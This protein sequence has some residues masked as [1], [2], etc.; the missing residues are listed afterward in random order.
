MGFLL[1]DFP[2]QKTLTFKKDILRHINKN[3]LE[4]SCGIICSNLNKITYHPLENENPN[5][6]NSFSMNKLDF[7]KFNPQDI[8]AIFHSH[9]TGSELASEPDRTQSESLGIPYYIYGLEKKTFTLFYPQSFKPKPLLSRFFFPEFQDCVSLV[10][11]FFDINLK[12][13]LSKHIDNWAR[14]RN[15]ESNADLIRQ[16]DVNFHEVS[17]AELTGD[18]LVFDIEKDRPFHLGV[19]TESKKILHQ[20]NDQFSQEVYLTPELR[21]KVYKI[22]RYKDL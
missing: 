16:L 7:A 2:E 20:P 14:R 22:Y 17:D 9:P 21:K 12:I 19:F 18:V 6:H 4:E 13:K 11:D 5:K 10:K 8:L 15:N 1:V 3:P